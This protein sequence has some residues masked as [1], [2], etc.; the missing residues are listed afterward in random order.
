MIQC[1]CGTG[2]DADDRKG[3]GCHRGNSVAFAIDGHRR[4][5]QKTKSR[6]KEIRRSLFYLIF[7]VLYKF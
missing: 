3:L 2:R 7:Y 1:G 6:F 5:R 4:H